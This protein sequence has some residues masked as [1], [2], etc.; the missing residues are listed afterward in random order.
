MWI[1]GYIPAFRRNALSPS[2]GLSP[3]NIDIFT[4]V[5]ASNLMKIEF[6]QLDHSRR[7]LKKKGKRRGEREEKEDKN[8][9][10]ILTSFSYVCFQEIAP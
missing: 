5:K 4:A 6:S 3:T 2:S 9:V 7:R 8:K 1:F 10:N